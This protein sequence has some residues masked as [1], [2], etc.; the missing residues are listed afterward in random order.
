MPRSLAFGAILLSLA[1]A[2]SV[3]AQERLESHLGVSV[4]APAGFAKSRDKP[5]PTTAIH[6]E[7][8][9]GGP[10]FVVNAM[11]MGETLSEEELFKQ[12]RATFEVEGSVVELPSGRFL[13]IELDLELENGQTYK[14]RCYAGLRG[15]TA[16]YFF[17]SRTSPADF[18]RLERGF[19]S[20]VGGAKF[21]EPTPEAEGPAEEL[22]AEDSPP[23][24]VPTDKA[25]EEPQPGPTPAP[26]SGAPESQPPALPLESGSS[27]PPTSTPAQDAPAPAHPSPKD[28]PGK[29]VSARDEARVLQRLPLRLVSFKSEFD[30]DHWAARNL[31]DGSATSG[32]CSSPAAKGQPHPF[33]FDLG[34][35]QRLARL[36]FDAACMDEGDYAGVGAKGY[37]V[38]GSSEGPQGEF[39]ELARGELTRGANDQAIEL[40]LGSRARWLRLTLTSNHGHKDLTELMEVRA[41]AQGAAGFRLERARLSLQRNGAATAEPF[42]P[43]ARVWVNFKPRG[44]A[45]N[46]EGKVWLSVDLVLEDAQG[47]ELLVREQVVDHTGLPPAR[48]LSSFVSLY[49]TLPE[50]FPSGS[51]VVRILA[52]DGF[53][54]ASAAARLRFSIGTN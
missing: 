5:N 13:R 53:G 47:K 42:A 40:P 50:G 38:E 51:Y 1:A 15:R 33:V 18:A 27:Q 45:K 8:K 3:S 28:V 14:Q 35:E 21:F 46:A 34:A 9:P 6:L 44:L 17:L 25:P 31:I 24:D 4:A 20:F 26:A 54:E 19:E 11:K 2:G 7:E 12:T 10:A 32:W 48:P 29:G 49:L 36:E 22:P 41:Y 23:E 16:Y 30:P 52:R 39:V 37:V 43:G